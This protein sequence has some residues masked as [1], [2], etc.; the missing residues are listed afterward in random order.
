MSQIFWRFSDLLAQTSGLYG[1]QRNVSGFT[2]IDQTFI[3]L[4]KARPRGWSQWKLQR[5]YFNAYTTYGKYIHRFLSHQ[6]AGCSTKDR[7]NGGILVD[8]GDQNS[9]P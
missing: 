7:G 6:V 3:S 8:L 1:S 2:R 9:V 4:Q 5:G